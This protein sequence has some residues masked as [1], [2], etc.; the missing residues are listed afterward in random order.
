MGG[1]ETW[2]MA[3][4]RLWSA[5]GSVEM[6]FL[7][8]SGHAGMF[9]EEARALGARVHYLR[10]EKD[11]LPKF[12]REYRR[13]LRELRYDAIHDHS[14]YASGWRYGMIADCLP[15][16]RV[17][18]IHNPWIHIGSYYGVTRRRR[19]T[20]LLG[21]QLVGLLATH[22]CGTSSEVMS[23]YGFPAGRSG[24]LRNLVVHCGFDVSR[25]S[26]PR[27]PDR[28][29]VLDEFGFHEDTKLILFVGRLDP[30]LEIDHPRNHKNSWLAALIARE[31]ASTD[32]RVRLLMVGAGG[33]QR[34]QMEARIADWGLG[35]RLKLLGVRSDVGRL[36]RAADV[37]LFPSAEEG[38]GM[39]A[40]EAQAAGLP[41]LASTSVPREAMVIPQLFHTLSLEAP[42]SQWA[43]R[44]LAIMEHP[45][46]NPAACEAALEASD[47][48][49]A[50]SAKRLEAIYRGAA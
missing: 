48:A 49:I 32:S 43:K 42:P 36:M 11:G 28:R 40:V 16:V 33:A 14:D 30:D 38:L 45:R 35:D 21:K 50:N 46:P 47:Y 34:A 25:Y 19:L 7:A 26:G 3:L 13:L 24:R 8:T 39:V 22:V 1:A 44:L 29:A 15:P 10:Y 5:A 18:H 9:D 31:T 37:L 41:V 17:S 4:L 27:A 6:D 20:A 2:L 23:R 12:A